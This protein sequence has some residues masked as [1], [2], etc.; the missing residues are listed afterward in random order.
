MK[1]FIDLIKCVSRWLFTVTMLIYAGVACYWLWYPYDV[2][3]IEQP[4]K[5]MNPDKTVHAGEMLTYRFAYNKRMNV[6]GTLT[7]KL[8]NTYKLEYADV[9]VTAPIGKDTDQMSLL[10]PSFA[11]S[12]EHYIWW[13]ASYKVNPLRTVVVTAESEHFMVIGE[14]GVAG[15]PGPPGPQGETGHIGKSGPQGPPGNIG[16]TG[17]AG[18]KGSGFWGGK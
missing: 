17:K 6:S 16:E 15:L 12:G 7:R 18:E 8:V 3:Q 14:E 2:I 1:S 10:I 4:I 11:H 13:S 9:T 5:I